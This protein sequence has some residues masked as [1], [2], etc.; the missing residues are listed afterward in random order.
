MSYFP[1]FINLEKKSCII[2]GGGKVAHRK[3]AKMLSY[4]A[5]V[6]VIAPEI[7]E[8]IY[9]LQRTYENVT[10]IE[11][12]YEPSDLRGA[13]LVIAATNDP[14]INHK[15]MEDA[16]EIGAITNNS[17]QENGESCDMIF[18]A[19]IQHGDLSIGI[20]T[21]GKSPEFAARL[22][23]KIEQMLPEDVDELIQ[24]LGIMREDVKLNVEDE[25][26]RRKIIKK[27][28]DRV[29]SR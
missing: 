20:T 10:I 15:V 18:P 21:N 24:K 28:V 22:R 12:Q 14:E 23:E 9:Q 19:T 5:S 8:E 16:R 29:L 27:M 3:A 1:I 13:F 11:K 4:G 25:G 2:V 17:I 26:E 6:T 7:E